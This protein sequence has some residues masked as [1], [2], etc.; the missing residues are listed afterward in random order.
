M[1]EF[2]SNSSDD[3]LDDSSGNKPVTS[4]GRKR[5]STAAPLKSPLKSAASSRKTSKLPVC[6]ELED[7]VERFEEVLPQTF[8]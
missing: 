5:K 1:R 4:K 8:L 6:S 2:L 7:F 3:S